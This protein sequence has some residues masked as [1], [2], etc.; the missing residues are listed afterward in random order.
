M[1]PGLTTV[2]E[3]LSLLPDSLRASVRLAASDEMMWPARDAAADIDPC[4]SNYT[5][6]V[7]F[8]DRGAV[9]RLW[10]G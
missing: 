5:P 1:R 6:L 10:R 4:R 7:A 2:T 3:N 8:I 9:I